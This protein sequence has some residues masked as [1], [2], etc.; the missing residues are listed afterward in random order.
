MIKVRRTISLVSIQLNTILDHIMGGKQ[1]VEEKKTVET[2][3]HV[4]NNVIIEAVAANSTLLTIMCLELGFV[5]LIGFIQLVIYT[6]C[7]HVKNLKK[8]Y[9]NRAIRDQQNNP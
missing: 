9:S 4:N 2:S 1:S 3:G 7:N 6:Y 5:I 8:K